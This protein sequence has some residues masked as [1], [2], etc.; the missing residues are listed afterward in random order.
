MIFDNL[1]RE[2]TISIFTATGELVDQ[3]E[4]GFDRNLD[5]STPWDLRNQNGDLVT[6]GL[7][8]Y[9]IEVSGAKNKVGK[10]AIIR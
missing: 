10:F 3:I 9:S 7:Y 1:P 8:F 4:H 5:G 2:C 6:P